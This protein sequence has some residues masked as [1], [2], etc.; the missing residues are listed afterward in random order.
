M[1]FSSFGLYF[2]QKKPPVQNVDEFLL[3]PLL[4]PFFLE[5]GAG[6][7]PYN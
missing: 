5:I 1:P 3:Y 7:S 2:S 4:Y 6:V